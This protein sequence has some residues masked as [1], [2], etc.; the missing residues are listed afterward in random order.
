MKAVRHT[1]TLDY[2]DGPILF[3]ARDAIGGHYLAAA[4]DTRSGK[5]LFAV[6]GVS[7]ERLHEFRNGT[8]DLRDLMVE[9]G[10]DEWYVACENPATE[11][12]DLELQASPLSTSRYL[13]KVGYKLDAA[14]SNDATVLDE[15]H[16]R[17]SLAIQRKADPSETGDGGFEKVALEGRLVG[18]DLNTGAWRLESKGTVRRGTAGDVTML[19]GLIVGG[20]YRFLCSAKT[21]RGGA[22]GRQVVTLHLEST[23]ETK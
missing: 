13:P 19:V 6:V 14:T 17:D 15:S 20:Q 18:A 8:V 2:Y 12:F 11:D 10:S 7:P 3:E 4:A 23:E 16:P 5:T 9:A 1:A 22:A 21:A